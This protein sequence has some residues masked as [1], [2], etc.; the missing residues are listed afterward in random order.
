[1]SIQDIKF[2][3]ERLGGYMELATRAAEC[4]RQGLWDHAIAPWGDAAKVACRPQNV[5]WAKLR[6]TVCEKG[7]ERRWGKIQ[8]RVRG[9]AA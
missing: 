6:V 9:E 8:V 1:M 2:S 5:G 3:R 4:E 7:K